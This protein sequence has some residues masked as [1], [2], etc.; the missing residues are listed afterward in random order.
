MV[1]VMGF[2]FYMGNVLVRV[3][4]NRRMISFLMY[5]N[6]EFSG[7]VNGRRNVSENRVSNGR[8]YKGVIYHIDLN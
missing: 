4:K 5:W 1:R 3:W 7:G 6:R 2:E 8:I